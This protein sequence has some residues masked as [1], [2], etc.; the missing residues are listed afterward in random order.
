MTHEYRATRTVYRAAS[1][2]A[3]AHDSRPPD[4]TWRVMH[5]DEMK[6]ADLR[7]HEEVIAGVSV[8]VELADDLDHVERAR[9]DGPASLHFPE[10]EGFDKMLTIYPG[11]LPTIRR[12]LDAIEREWTRLGVYPAPKPGSSPSVPVSSWDDPPPPFEQRV[13]LNLPL[14]VCSLAHAGTVAHRPHEYVAGAVD[15]DDPDLI[16]TRA[17]CP[18]LPAAQGRPAQV[19]CSARSVHIQHGWRR[20]DDGPMLECPGVYAAGDD[21]AL[22]D[23]VARR[24]K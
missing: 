21:V 12:A 10:A 7:G 24:P 5:D 3:A 6:P 8:V 18:G 23:V 4:E 13:D 22:L 19:R 9:A 11:D 16:G 1:E 2:H 20:T 17:R 14:R 15:S